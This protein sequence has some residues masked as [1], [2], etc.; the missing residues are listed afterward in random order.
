M[1]LA[2]LCLCSEFVTSIQFDF[3][4]TCAHPNYVIAKIFCENYSPNAVVVHLQT[5][6]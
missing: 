6:F 2:A 3:Q 5:E 1:I 4:L